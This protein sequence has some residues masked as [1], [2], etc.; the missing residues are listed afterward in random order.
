[1]FGYKSY[2]IGTVSKLHL[3]VIRKT[4]GNLLALARQTKHVK[5]QS[6][7]ARTLPNFASVGID[8]ICTFLLTH[9]WALATAKH[10][11]TAKRNY[12]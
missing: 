7:H 2:F 8:L 4:R 3:N 11:A 5:W 10:G 1:M 9:A 12:R 6:A